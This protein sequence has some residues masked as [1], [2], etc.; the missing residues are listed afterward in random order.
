MKREGEEGQLKTEGGL[1]DSPTSS[2]ATVCD[3]SSGTAILKSSLCTRITEL[4]GTLLRC[5]GLG[6]ALDSAF[7]TRSRR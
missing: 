6:Q 7:L 2:A 1:G 4:Q 5:R 3:R